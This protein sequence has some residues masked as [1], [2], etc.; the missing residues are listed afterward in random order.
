MKKVLCFDSWTGGESHFSRLIPAF[1]VRGLELHLLHLGSW[2]SEPDSLTETSIGELSVRDI[3]FYEGSSLDEILAI[4]QPVAAI[5]LSTDT[6]AH[7][8]F[9]RYCEQKSIPTLNLYHGL[10][11]LTES[12]PGSETYTV[13]WSAHIRYVISKLSKLLRYTFPCYIRALTKTNASLKDWVRFF[14]DIIHMGFNLHNHFFRCAAADAKTTKCG[15]YV[16]ADVE[17]AIRFYGFSQEDVFV[18]GNPDLMRFGLDEEMIGKWKS[19]VTENKSIMY[20]ETG[21]SSVGMFFLSGHDFADHIISTAQALKNQGYKLFVKLKPHGSNVNLIQKRL[22]IAGIEL[23]NNDQFLKKLFTCSACIVETTSLAMLPALMGMP[24]MLA[25]YGK[26]SSL[27]FG[28]IL[29][30]YPRSHVLEDISDVTDFLHKN[31][32]YP[33][34]ANL[35]KWINLNVGPLPTEKMPDRV[36]AIVE[37]MLSERNSDPT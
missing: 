25:K 12:I 11:E 20:I 27:G 34:A 3:T 10:V 8:A 33:D 32:Q 29:V 30:N 1:R 36:V 37:A 18:V 31:A 13:S 5:L 2:G 28:K 26:L 22:E 14:S 17:H 35:E 7:R 6:F 24:L 4:E 19:P 23:V 9:I 15:V 16:H 21:F